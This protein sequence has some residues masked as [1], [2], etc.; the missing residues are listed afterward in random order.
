[1]KYLQLNPEDFGLES[2]PEAYGD[3]MEEI[4]KFLIKS[5]QY[6]IATMTMDELVHAARWAS[7]SGM[8]KDTLCSIIRQ[9]LL[10]H[11]LVYKLVG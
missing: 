7:V 10:E 4:Q 2:H 6:K 1:M 5:N 8:V 11:G 9:Y 3:T